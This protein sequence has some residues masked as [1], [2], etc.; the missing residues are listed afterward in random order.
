MNDA[1]IRTFC[2]HGW[3][4]WSTPFTGTWTTREV[5]GDETTQEIVTGYM[6]QRRMCTKCGKV[7]YRKCT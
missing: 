4:K 7:V 6:T 1:L 5:L 3:E 2:W